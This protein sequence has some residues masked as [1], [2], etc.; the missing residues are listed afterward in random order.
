[1][2]GVDGTVIA[3]A[4]AVSLVTGIVFGL[5]PA[6]QAGRTELP[7]TLR[8]GG[9]GATG[10]ALL[11][12]MRP[13]LVAAEVALSLVLLVGAGLMLRS[14]AAL[15]SVDTGFATENRL[16]FR[17]SLPGSRYPDAAAA[18]RF[19]TSFLE[20]VGSLP[21]VESAAAVSTLLL[22]RLP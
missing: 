9:R 10:S 18:D 22:S 5:A 4:I 7:S 16:V 19:F 20:R 1:A 15:Q 3:F 13:I 8:E 17:V 11:D 12:R 21:G 14:F 2:L 6:L